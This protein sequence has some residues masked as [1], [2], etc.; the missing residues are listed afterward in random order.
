MFKNWPWF[1]LGV[2]TVSLIENWFQNN[3]ILQWLGLVFFSVSLVI[4]FIWSLENDVL[5]KKG[6]ESNFWGYSY[7]DEKGNIQNITNGRDV[8]IF[9]AVALFYFQSYK[10]ATDHIFSITTLIILCIAAVMLIMVLIN[11]LENK[12]PPS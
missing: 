6:L 2:G 11:W 10:T 12:Y 4:L 1:F 3:A 7:L 8:F 5:P 9:G